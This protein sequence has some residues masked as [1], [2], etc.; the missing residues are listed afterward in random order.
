MKAVFLTKSGGPDTVEVRETAMPISDGRKTLVRVV[1]A[2]LNYADVVIR[3]GLYPDAPRFPFI[4]GY[5]FS[6]IVETPNRSSR[7]ATGDRVM[8]VTCFGAQAEYVLLDDDQLFPMPHGMSFEEAA[9]L[10][11]NYLTAYF[12]LFRLGNLRSGERVLIHS[13]AGGVG[14]AAVQL[15]QTEKAE[16]FGTTSS[17]HKIAYLESLGVQHPIN[18]KDRDFAKEIRSVVG[19]KGID[20]VLDPIGGK[21]F[22]KSFELLARGGR[23]I[24]YGV[25]DLISGGRRNLPKVFWKYLNLPRLKVLDLIQ[26]NRGVFGLALNRLV[27]EIELIAGPLR[28]LINL[29]AQGIIKPKIS[30]VFRAEKA[31]EAHRLME[32][33]K[34]TGKL[35]LRFENQTM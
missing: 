27:G 8:G 9:A 13:C 33:G 30:A 3:S 26:N 22:R 12:A 35:I 10:P 18:Y 21:V 23:I 15:A 20:M 29:Y 19:D 34:S 24:C 11:V 4:A 17:P 28:E 25:T 5:E 14:T 6:G 16:I 1:A 2:G 31:N 32:S 7:F